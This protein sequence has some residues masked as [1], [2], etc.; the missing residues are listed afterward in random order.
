MPRCHLKRSRVVASVVLLGLLGACDGTPLQQTPPKKALTPNEVYQPLDGA[1]LV[2][3]PLLQSGDV[4]SYFPVDLPSFDADS[5]LILYQSTDALGRSIPVSGTVLV[6]R[7]PWL[8]GGR[9]P[10]VAFAP[11]TLGVTDDC[12]ASKGLLSGFYMETS[13][14]DMALE[15]GWAVAI[16]DYEGLGTAGPHTYV[17]APS[18][19]HTVLDSVRAAIRTP[20]SGLSQSAP[21]VLW[22]YS[23]GGGSVAAAAEAA[24]TYAPELQLKG[25]A[26]GGVPADLNG[27]AANLEGSF[28]FGFLMAASLGLD[29]AYPDLMLGSYLNAAGKSSFDAMANGTKSGC[30]IDL[31]LTYPL[32]HISDYTT[33]N[34]LPTP[35]WQKRLAENKLGMIK[36][37][38]PA[39]L[40]HGDIDEIIPNAV[41]VGLRT[42]WC[43]LGATVKWSVYPLGEHLLAQALAAGDVVEWLDDRI[44]GNPATSTC[45]Q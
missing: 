28:F 16:T 23:Q 45:G 12:A 7:S 42:R 6:P 2:G 44:K 37:T 10:I 33:S 9:R 29:T 8:G 1:S 3:L 38:V 18:E 19:A 14:V 36:P 40:Y 35:A 21:V 43:A 22:G 25:V 15:K 32:Q 41:G 20:G 27:V 13:Y 39:F 11:E 17:V 34:P 30:L 24:P 26:A 5:W 31:I 4:I